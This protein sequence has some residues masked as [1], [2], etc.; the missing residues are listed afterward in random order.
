MYPKTE[1]PSSWLTFCPLKKAK[2]F[3]AVTA[4]RGGQRGTIG[5]CRVDVW[6][7]DMASFELR[8]YKSIWPKSCE[9]GHT[10]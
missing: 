3:C 10:R 5:D 7:L 6:E 4:F 2:R 8:E 9:A 1:P